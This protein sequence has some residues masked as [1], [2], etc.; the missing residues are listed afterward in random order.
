MANDFVT[1]PGSNGATFRSLDDGTRQ[2]PA[3]LTSYVITIGSPNVLQ[4]VDLTHGLPVQSQTGAV[5]DYNLKQYGGVAVGAA[6]A[7]H[8]QPGTGAAFPVTDNGGSLTVDDGG[9]SLTVDGA[10][11]VSG[12]VAVTGNVD[13]TPASPLGNDYL[14]VRLTDG[15][16]FLGALPV[17][18]NNGSLSIDDNGGSLTVDG[19]VGITGS[20]AVT[21]TFWQ[22]TQP[23]S[24]TVTAN[25]GGAPWTNNVTQIGGNAILA[26]NGATGT[27][28]PRVTIASDNSDV[29]V[30]LQ[31]QTAGGATPYSYISA[32]SQDEASVKGSAGQLYGYAI[33]N[34]TASAKYVKIYDKASAAAST[35]TPKLRIMVPANG[36]ANLDLGHGVPFASGIRHRITTGIADNDTGAVAANDILLN[37]FFK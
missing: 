37:L 30:K 2:W 21:G 34:T 33:F 13:V 1:N 7:I 11:T 19:S 36:G 6:N 35:D 32:G 16:N 27:G 12:S 9:G 10:V 28:S 29:P 5:W 18:D 15:T 23:V 20:V 3:G 14:P 17:T 26:G 4:L 31:P 24:G 22:A 8:V 25:Q